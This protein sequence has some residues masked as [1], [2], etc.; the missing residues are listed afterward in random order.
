M[1]NS[2]GPYI[3]NIPDITSQLQDLKRDDIPSGIISLPVY[4]PIENSVCFGSTNADSSH[5]ELARL[6]SSLRFGMIDEN[7]V[8]PDYE[9]LRQQCRSAS[10]GKT[11]PMAIIHMDFHQLT[12]SKKDPFLVA[13]ARDETK[14]LL[15]NISS[16]DLLQETSFMSRPM[17]ANIPDG[18]IAVF[19]FAN[20][21]SFNNTERELSK[22]EF[23][24]GDGNGLQEIE[25][26]EKIEISYET[27]GIKEL[28][29]K[30]TFGEKSY[31][32]YSTIN[33]ISLNLPAPTFTIPDLKARFYYR[34]THAF[35][36]VSVYCANN[37]HLVYPV[38]FWG[39]FDTGIKSAS[40]VNSP[41]DLMEFNA[42]ELF[43]AAYKRFLKLLLDRG[44]D[45]IILEWRNPRDYIQNNGFL[46]ATL[47]SKINNE[48]AH[49]GGV[50]LTGSMGGI[51]ARWTALYMEHSEGKLEFGIHN[52]DKIIYFDSPHEG[53]VTCMGLQY[54]TEFLSNIH[55]SC[56]DRARDGIKIIKSPASRQ[57]LVQ[58]F[59]SGWGNQAEP[60]PHADRGVL[61]KTFKD[62]GDYPKHAKN[63]AVSSGNGK[64]SPQTSVD[65]K[66]EMK[67]GVLLLKGGVILMVLHRLRALPN[68]PTKQP[69]YNLVGVGLNSNADIQKTLPYD[70]CPGGWYPFIPAI[71]NS[72]NSDRTM[73]F[74]NT[75]FIPTTSSL[76]IKN[77]NLYLK[78]DPSLVTNFEDY[79]VPEKNEQHAKLNTANRAWVL[80]LLGSRS[81]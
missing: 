4:N 73:P 36:D 38:Y 10:K 40:S 23:D 80:K 41:F 50:I 24:S 12:D 1:N 65:G 63:Y 37:T 72:L 58:L 33:V 27:E 35:G 48:H 15:S 77:D 53:A 6:I 20:D 9:D 44:F 76:G 67:P 43:S 17:V 19:D 59:T 46:V 13:L 70:S 7:F 45:I 75:C 22:I 57:M 8:L 61:V 71:G 60:I 55:V 34:G 51:I 54:V 21:W 74:E 5:N 25:K 42:N 64:G 79:F 52:L 69:K 3:D 81:S 39:G 18:A 11:I 68:Y 14:N 66:I 31:E 32:T 47:I 78:I 62:W 26:N 49:N 30:A 29:V 16:E 28:R 2:N 56:T